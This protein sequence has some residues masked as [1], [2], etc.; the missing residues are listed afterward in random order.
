MPEG[1]GFPAA[2]LVYLMAVIEISNDFP[3]VFPFG[4]EKSIPVARDVSIF[5]GLRMI[6]KDAVLVCFGVMRGD[7]LITTAADVLF[8]VPD[9]EI[10][11]KLCY[12]CIL[13]PSSKWMNPCE[14]VFP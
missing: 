11:L 2:F 5:V 1:R 9:H 12:P 4:L 3:R 10:L 13:N 14:N 6:E 8:R 7:D